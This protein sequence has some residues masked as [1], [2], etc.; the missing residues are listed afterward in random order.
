[1]ANHHPDPR[2]RHEDAKHK[3]DDKDKDDKDDDKNDDNDGKPR[4]HTSPEAYLLSLRG[5][6]YEEA[7]S[8]LLPLA[9]VGPKVADCICLMSLD[10]REA[11][12]VD[13]HVRSIAERLYGVRLPGASK[14]L[15]DQGYRVIQQHFW[16]VFGSDAGWAHS[17]RVLGWSF[18]AKVVRLSHHYHHPSLHYHHHHHTTI[19]PYAPSLPTYR[20]C[21]R[22]T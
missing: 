14:T 7:R 11:L 5:L 9:G 22:R 16:S 1:M 2:E 6:T 19:S 18:S 13:T 15:T 21:S 8:A 3:D 10:K 4:A 12:P 17:V 20:S